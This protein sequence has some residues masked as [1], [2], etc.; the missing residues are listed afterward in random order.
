MEQKLVNPLNHPQHPVNSNN[1]VG[2]RIPLNFHSVASN[3]HPSTPPSP[4][5]VPVWL[6]PVEEIHHLEVDP[7]AY[8]ANI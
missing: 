1:S 3:E 6:N 5:L 7:T 8:L 2:S 4:A